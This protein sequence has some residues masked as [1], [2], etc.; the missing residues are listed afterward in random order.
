MDMQQLLEAVEKVHTLF[1]DKNPAMDLEKH[2]L[3][4]TLKLGEEVGELNEQIMGHFK[5]G[6]KEKQDKCNET[7][8]AHEVVDV[9][10]TAMLVARSL[11]IDISKALQEK[12]TIIQERLGIY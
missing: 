8:L 6:R 3:F 7:L 10:F 5:H 11:D 12:T 1:M 2:T 4:R 9:I